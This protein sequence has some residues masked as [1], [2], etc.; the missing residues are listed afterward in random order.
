MTK[1]IVMVT[2]YV[3]HSVVNRYV[4]DAIVGDLDSVRPSVVDYY[5]GKVCCS[6]PT[7]L[8]VTKKL[9]CL[10]PK[11]VSVV[12]TVSLVSMF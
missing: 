5:R 3:T 9:F 12:L 11:W 8:I 10:Y 6:P 7:T 2:H 1:V 4:P